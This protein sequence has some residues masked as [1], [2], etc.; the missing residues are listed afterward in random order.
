MTQI[1]GH[2]VLKMM[3]ESGKIYTKKSLVADI[4]QKFGA[5][6][7]FHTCSAEGM[8]A[9]EMVAFLEAKGKLVPLGGGFQTAANL[10]CQH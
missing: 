3:L 7:R 6:A 5:D 4:I 8:T 2:D 9:E 10:M 1:H